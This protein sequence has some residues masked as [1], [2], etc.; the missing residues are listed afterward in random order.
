[1]RGMGS[2]ATFA[3]GDLERFECIGPDQFLYLLVMAK[4]FEDVDGNPGHE[5]DVPH[6]MFGVT[7]YPQVR[8]R[9]FDKR[10]DF[11]IISNHVERYL[12]WGR[13]VLRRA[14][15]HHHGVVMALRGDDEAAGQ[16]DGGGGEHD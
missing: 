16:G 11:W 14:V 7:H 9:L 4:V 1:M 3:G 6:A 15:R 12:V 2:V 10:G 8:V 13:V 5:G